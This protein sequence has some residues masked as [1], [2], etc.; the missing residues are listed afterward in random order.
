MCTEMQTEELLNE[1]EITF[2]PVEKP[3]GLN[4]SFHKD[5]CAHCVYL[6]KDLSEFAGPWLPPRALR[7]MH[8]EMG[9]LS[10]LAWRWV[11]PSYLTHC[12]SVATN[13]DD[14]ETEFLVCNLGPDK[15][16]QTEALER[17]SALNLHQIVCLIHFLEWCLSHKHWAEYCP[18]DIE[19][20]LSF[21]RT[22]RNDVVAEDW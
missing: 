20:A 16:F 9:S 18:E 8:Q 5:D 17:L 11:L 4:I 13:Y 10:A 12:V 15:Q 14:V 21:M 7:L 6:R 1:I 2:P 22:V 19:K 3:N